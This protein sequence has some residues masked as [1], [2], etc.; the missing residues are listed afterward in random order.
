MKK[1]IEI[2]LKKDKETIIVSGD[3]YKKV[4]FSYEYEK[5]VEQLVPKNIDELFNYVFAIEKGTFNKENLKEIINHEVSDFDMDTFK[6]IT[7]YV[8]YR[9]NIHKCWRDCK[10]AYPSKCEKVFD[11][12]K[13]NI[14]K[15]DFVKYGFQVIINDEI[16]R[17]VVVNCK[18]YCYK[19][20]INRIKSF[21]RI[22]K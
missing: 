10:N 1:K 16:E 11:L 5:L 22:K 6:K 7:L 3:N 9:K 19:P 18:N 20:D 8:I 13:E 12:P 15:Y 14:E 4:P 17:F 21:V 2:A